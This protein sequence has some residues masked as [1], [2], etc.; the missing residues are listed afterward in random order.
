MN[1]QFLQFIWKHG[2]YDKQDMRTVT[3]NPIEVLSGGVQNSNAGPDFTNARIK[4]GNV[5]WA[6]NVEIHC[7][8]SDWNKH[9]HQ[10]D[11]A[12]NNVILHV[13]L[14]HDCRNAATDDSAPDIYE[15]KYDPRFE[16]RYRSL[17][18]EQK[19]PLCA[20]LLPCVQDFSWQHFLTLLAFERFEERTTHIAALLDSS[21]NDW[22][23]AFL[24]MLFRAFG[25]G[26]NADPLE[27]LAQSISPAYIAKHRSSLLQM[28]ALL[29]GQAGFL[30]KPPQ[31]EYQHKL[32]QEY[33]LLRAKFSLTPMP[34]HCWRFLR[35]R[36]QN[37]PTMRIAQLAALLHSTQGLFAKIME[38][39][40][41]ND[42][43]ALFN[44]EVSEYWRTHYSFDAAEHSHSTALGKK[45]IERLIANVAAPIMYC[46][47]K[48]N[49]EEIY[50][51]RAAGL[52]EELPPE[53]NV[54]TAIWQNA[55]MPAR[56]MLE[57]QALIQL[58]TEYCHKR[59]CLHCAVGR[60]MIEG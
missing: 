31:D 16:D 37:F 30:E 47:G 3:G 26:V 50:C 38:A 40:Y 42:I 36:P 59:R 11:G 10:Q 35:I 53:E 55:K 6:G 21:R 45:S 25:F 58:T 20:H 19:D 8:S 57:S 49:D 29:F 34:K 7:R 2:L 5:M 4:I 9:R 27:R 24:Q 28:E 48:K 44:T 23:Q 52:L 12:Y 17:M 56:N 1:E 13:V 22:E 51:R 54:H 43:L 14:H 39:R 46:Y 15:I 18:S 32:Q 33:T 60:R 41:A